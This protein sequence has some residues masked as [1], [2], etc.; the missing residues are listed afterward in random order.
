MCQCQCED[1]KK[2]ISEMFT[3]LVYFFLKIILYQLQEI[4][5]QTAAVYYLARSHEKK[6]LVLKLSSA[7]NCEISDFYFSKTSSVKQLSERDVNSN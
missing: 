1:I 2:H 7:V 4:H 5:F 3:S 6:Q